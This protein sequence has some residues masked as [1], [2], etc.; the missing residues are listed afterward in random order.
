MDAFEAFSPHLFFHMAART[1][2][3][4]QRIEDYAANVDGV[5]NVIDAL[6]SLSDLQR[7]VFASSMLVC[8]LGYR[9]RDDYDYNPTTAYGASKV[10]GE[11][12]VR[13][14]GSRIPWV[15]VR[16][17]SLWG[18][19]FDI[20]YRRFFDAVRA[21]WYV[22]PKGLAVRRSY[23]F[24][25]N[26]VAQ[27]ECLANADRSRVCG[28]TFYLADYRPVEL[29]AWAE[30]IRRSFQAPAIREVP[31]WVLRCAAAVGDVLRAAG[32]KNPPLTS[33][34]LSNLTKDAVM[35]TAPLEAI[36][37]DTP[38]DAERGVELTVDWIKTTQLERP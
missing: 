8:G 14:L 29:R 26:C 20:P 27:L 18:P 12:L 24:V 17:T 33:L 32:V 37:G 31:I 19:W 13:S 23:G 25:L 21:G 38:Y 7:V 3:E 16:P 34:R 9:P 35:D 10:E 22:H 2:L 1:D 28:R 11:R 15:M 30:C 6:K 5:R 36:C 4:G